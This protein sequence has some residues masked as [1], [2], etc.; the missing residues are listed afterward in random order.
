MFSKYY[1]YCSYFLCDGNLHCFINENE[2][3]LVTALSARKFASS[4][5]QYIFNL[6]PSN[7]IMVQELYLS[8]NNIK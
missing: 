2:Q 6:V 1:Y 4:R 8:S 5:L 3:I 7:G